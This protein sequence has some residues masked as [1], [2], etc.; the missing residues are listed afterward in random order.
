MLALTRAHLSSLLYQIL[1][2]QDVFISYHVFSAGEAEGT[3]LVQGEEKTS[4][5]PRGS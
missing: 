5:R 1:G 4:V 3:G 2:S